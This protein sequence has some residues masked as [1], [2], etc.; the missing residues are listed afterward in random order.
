MALLI[1][2]RAL[3]SST[4]LLVY[5]QT[6][7]LVRYFNDYENLSIQQ[8]GLEIILQE[9][10]K[11]NYLFKYINCRRNASYYDDVGDERLILQELKSKVRQH[12]YS[13]RED[14]GEIE[15]IDYNAIF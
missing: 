11:H 6:D 10:K 4:K 3:K 14:I 9:L 1:A 12:S 15:T 5:S 13:T 2:L 7:F 8:K